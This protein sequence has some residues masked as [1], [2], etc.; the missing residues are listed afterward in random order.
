MKHV[1]ECCIPAINLHKI[2][3]DTEISCKFLSSNIKQDILHFF[4]K[5]KNHNTY[6]IFTY[7]RYSETRTLKFLIK[8]IYEIN[9]CSRFYIKLLMHIQYIKFLKGV[10]NSKIKKIIWKITRK[11]RNCNRIWSHRLSLF[12][13]IKVQ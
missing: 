13:I 12:Q 1:N 4:K 8:Y 9:C 5:H 6:L 11:R 2:M 10:I 7:T 3:H